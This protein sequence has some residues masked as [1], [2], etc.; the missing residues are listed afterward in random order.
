[1]EEN[2]DKK[3]EI[4]KWNEELLENRTKEQKDKDDYS[5]NDFGEPEK[6]ECGRQINSHGHCPRCDY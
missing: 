4:E 2:K 5:Y 6:C 1:M 3:Q